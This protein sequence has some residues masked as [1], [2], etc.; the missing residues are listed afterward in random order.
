MDIAVVVHLVEQIVR[1]VIWS[2]RAV[3]TCISTLDLGFSGLIAPISWATSLA[4]HPKLDRTLEPSS[5]NRLMRCV[6]D[7]FA[8][9]LN[10]VP[11]ACLELTTT[12]SGLILASKLTY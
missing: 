9:L 3:A 1:E 5:I 6:R 4:S 2:V 12:I 10:G 11:G 7:I 8:R